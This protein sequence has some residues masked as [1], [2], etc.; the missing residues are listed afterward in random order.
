VAVIFSCILAVTNYD[1]VSE[2]IRKTD[3]MQYMGKYG[4]KQLGRDTRP[5]AFLAVAGVLLVV[6]VVALMTVEPSAPQQPIE[7]QLD[8]KALLENK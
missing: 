1:V 3:K 4:T 6:G 2:T 7:K 8:A 5:L